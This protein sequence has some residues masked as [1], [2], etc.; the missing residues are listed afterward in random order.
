MLTTRY[1]WQATGHYYFC[2]CYHYKKIVNYTTQCEKKNNNTKKKF[3]K[4]LKAKVWE[5]QH[6]RGGCDDKA[7]DEKVRGIGVAATRVLGFLLRPSQ[8]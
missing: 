5:Q 2:W 3:E 1:K 7:H 6:K 8:Q 4:R